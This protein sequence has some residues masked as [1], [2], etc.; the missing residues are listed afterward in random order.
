M[1]SIPYKIFEHLK[2]KEMWP[3]IK[4]KVLNRNRFQDNPGVGLI[5]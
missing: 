2:I 4:K 5:R 1:F 3:I